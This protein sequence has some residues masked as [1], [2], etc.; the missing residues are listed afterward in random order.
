MTKNIRDRLPQGCFPIAYNSWDKYLCSAYYP[1]FEKFLFN[2]NHKFTT[3]KNL[4]E[5]KFDFYQNFGRE[6]L[7]FVRPDSGEKQFQAQLID[8]QDFDRF[9]ENGVQCSSKDEDLL[10]VSTPKKIIGEWRFVVTRKKE[11][12]AGSTYQYQ[13]KRTY[14][15]SAPA[16]ATELC[17]QILEVGH[18]PDSVFCIDVCQDGDGNYWLLELTSFSSAGLYAT[19]KDAVVKAVSEI[20]EEEWNALHPSE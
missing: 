3:L 14:I 17:K 15:P 18:Y 5:N 1:H 6:A 8:L 2:D 7:I 19:N 9:W 16:G 12:V 20:A 13:G 10:V 4:K 11:V